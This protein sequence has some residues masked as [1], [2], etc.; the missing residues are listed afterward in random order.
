MRKDPP[1]PSFSAPYAGADE[2]IAARLF[3]E[4]ELPPHSEA[5]IGGLATYLLEQIRGMPHRLGAIEDF[6]QEY[7]LSTEEGVAIMVLAEALLR[8]P[9]DATADRLIED[10]LTQP[11]WTQHAT[12]SEAL[13]VQASA[14]A[15]GLTAR[16]F[17]KP[18]GRSLNIVGALAR[19]IGMGAVRQAARQAMLILG[20]HFILGRNIEE[21]LHRAEHDHKVGTAYSFDMLGEGAR[22]AADAEAYYAA[23]AHAI[24]ALG[25]NAARLTERPGISVKLS[26]L[27][28][29]FEPTSRLRVMTELVPRLIR[30]V[31]LARGADIA[32]TIDAEEA[33]RL[34]LSLEVFEALCQEPYLA[35]WPGFG[36]AVQAYQKRAEAVLDHVL[37]LARYYDQ[38]FCVRLVKGAYWD[39]EI[40]RAQERGL[41][42]Y[43]VF[44]RKAMSD[45][46]YIVCAQKLLDARGAIFPQF[47]THN[48]LT[49]A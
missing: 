23:Y 48:A 46:N 18:D 26:A 30:L 35:G 19:R 28:P 7:S 33:D 37:A 1:P 9:D 17:G 45:L 27:H 20:S 16:T 44:T 22:T 42:D 12:E 34:E 43:P 3:T 4:A 8:V 10:K 15:L 2:A 31:S 32:V 49:V 29:R 21:A 40:K 6:L 24:E 38:R 13:L 11:A 39:T 47:A 25:A 5:R 36:L 14:W 41:D